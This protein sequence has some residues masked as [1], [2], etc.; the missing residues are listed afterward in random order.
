MVRN[1]G[2]SGFRVGDASHNL[3]RHAYYCAHSHRMRKTFWY[4][5]HIRFLKRACDQAT[6]VPIIDCAAFVAADSWVRGD[7]RDAFA[8]AK[9]EH[10][11]SGS[12]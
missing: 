11:F 9:L 7:N 5:L 8:R 1:F 4:G 10:L 2:K 6:N 3:K 12:I